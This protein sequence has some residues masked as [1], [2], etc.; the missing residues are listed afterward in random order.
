M[1]KLKFVLSVA[2]YYL[3]GHAFKYW[4]NILWYLIIVPA[5][6]YFAYATMGVRIA[7]GIIIFAVIVALIRDA[8]ELKDHYSSGVE[9]KK[10]EQER[11]RAYLRDAKVER[12][13][14]VSGNDAER[15]PKSGCNNFEQGTGLTTATICKW[16]GKEKWEH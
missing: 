8:K 11:L 9:A 16:C 4:R 14:E 15:Q 10:K 5:C 1:K 12:M 2:A 7:F 13:K 3:V 6:I